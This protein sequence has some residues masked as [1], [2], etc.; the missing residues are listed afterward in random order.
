MPGS[1]SW[2]TVLLTFVLHFSL[3]LALIAALFIDLE[4][5]ILPDEITVGGALLG[6][7]T[8]PWRDVTWTDSLLGGVFG[9]FVVYLPFYHGYRLLRGQPGMGLGDAKLLLLAGAWFGWQGALFALCAGA[10]QGTLF[11]IAILLARGRIEEPEAVQREREEL[12][13][14]LEQMSEEERARAEDE[15][16]DDI[17]LDEPRSGFMAARLAFGPFLVLAILEFMLAR[18]W[19]EAFVFD[20][21]WQA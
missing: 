2:T 17:L 20:T 5:M 4:H 3:G 9:F 10:I 12:Q 19:I 1:T 16:K 18:E 7:V 13:A 21:L 15:L 8:I 14:E 11:A 6:L